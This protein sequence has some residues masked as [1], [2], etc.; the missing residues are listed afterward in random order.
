MNPTP[1]PPSFSSVAQLV[2]RLDAEESSER[3]SV[4]DQD[5]PTWQRQLV[6]T[7]DEQALLALSVLQQYPIGVIVL[8]KINSGVSVPIDGRQRVTAL[9]RYSEGEIAI[10][11]LPRVPEE[12][13]GKK[14]RPEAG[15]RRPVYLSD[16]K[17]KSTTAYRS[18]LPLGS[19]VLSDTGGR[20]SW[21]QD[22]L[23]GHRG[24][25]SQEV[26]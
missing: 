25:C 23:G 19:P 14:Y 10:P 1:R 21:I 17:K 16:R 15:V 22:R 4:E 20:S 13:R 9:K 18:L 24:G 6:W 12:F 26:S 8:W 2:R 5:L 3:I 11:D 7:N